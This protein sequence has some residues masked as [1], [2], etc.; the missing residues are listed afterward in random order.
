MG[1]RPS[2]TLTKNLKDDC[3]HKKNP[4]GSFITFIIE[5][6]EIRKQKEAG[7]PR[8]W[9][10]DP[11]L[12][13]T[14][15]TNVRRQY[16]RASK[17]NQ[18]F[19][20]PIRQ[21]TELLWLNCLIIAHVIRPETM[22][23]LGIVDVRSWEAGEWVNKIRQCKPMFGTAY[24]CPAQYKTVLGY[25]T[26][27]EYIFGFLPKLAKLTWYKLYSR[28][29][30]YSITEMLDEILPYYN[31]K[32]EFATV[33]AMLQ[34]SE[35][36][37]DIIDPASEIP[38]GVGARPALNLMYPDISHREGILELL[39]LPDVKKICVTFSDVEHSLCEWRKYVELDTG[40]RKNTSRFRY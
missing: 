31:F 18:K 29:S 37:P 12:V 28:Y 9:T 2:N 30:G 3:H 40:I 34:L 36:A 11:I 38:I 32:N 15:F 13:N 17:F 6:D 8:P 27:E 26:R 35:V 5:R 23:H 4:I 10:D 19:L 39:K 24:Q 14:K 7:L 33:Q 22:E 1:S 25:E 20:K 16:D 21:D